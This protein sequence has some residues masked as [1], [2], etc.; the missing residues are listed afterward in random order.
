MIKSFTV[1]EVKEGLKH[2]ACND[3]DGCPFEDFALIDCEV[4]LLGLAAQAI[5]KYETEYDKLEKR[6]EKIKTKRRS[7]NNNDERA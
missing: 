4:K 6:L 1:A 3:C 2:C 7:K 5:E